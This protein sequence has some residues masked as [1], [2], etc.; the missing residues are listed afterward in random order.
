MEILEK[1]RMELETL[2]KEQLEVVSGRDWKVVH[3][4]VR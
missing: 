2:R 4:R 3:E 1:M